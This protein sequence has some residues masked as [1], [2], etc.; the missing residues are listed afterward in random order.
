MDTTI[1]ITIIIMIMILRIKNA[2][3][4]Q[5]QM[6]TIKERNRLGFVVETRKTA[7]LMAL[8]FFLFFM[9]WLDEELAHGALEK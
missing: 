5:T 6:G 7:V 1:T 4:S 2:T 9:H 8:L 3:T